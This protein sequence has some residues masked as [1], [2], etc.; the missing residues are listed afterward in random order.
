MSK[1]VVHPSQLKNPVLQG[2]KDIIEQSKREE[3]SQKP[4]QMNLYKLYPA[5]QVRKPESGVSFVKMTDEIKTF[6]ISETLKAQ[7]K[8]KHHSNRNKFDKAAAEEAKKK[9]AAQSKKG[10][11]KNKN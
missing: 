1:V 3:N 2:R 11:K 9:A 4:V 7:F 6:P 5:F 8:K 10:G